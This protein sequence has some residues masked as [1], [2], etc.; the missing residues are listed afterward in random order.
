MLPLSKT[1]SQHAE[2]FIDDAHLEK[3]AGAADLVDVG[4]LREVIAK[5]LDK[6]ALTVEETAVLLHARDPEL[7]E[8]VFA[9]ARDLKQ[10]VYGNRI[11]LFAPLYL[12][13]LCVNDCAY[14]GFQNK[15]K[16]VVRRTL[17]MEEIRQ[18]VVAMEN[19]GH[20]RLI[21]VF[22]EHPRYDADFIAT[23]IRDIYDVRSGHGEIRRVNVNAAPLDHAGFKTMETYH[24]KT[25]A[26]VH[27]HGTPKGDYLWRLDALSRAFEVGQDDLGIGALFGLSNWRF[28]VLGLVSHAVFLKDRYGCGPH[29]ISFPRLRPASGVDLGAD[30]LVND[31][32]FKFLIAVLRLA[33]PYTGLILTA[34]ETAELRRSAMEFGVSQ[35]DAGSC[36]ELGGYTE[37]TCGQRMEREQFTL[38][39]M[40]PLDKVIRE[41]SEQGHVPSFCTACYRLGRTGEHF[42][43]FAI[44]GF[45]KR[46]CTPNALTTFMEYLVDYATPE[47]AK[48]GLAQIQVE[49]DKLEDSPMKQTLVERLAKVRETNERDMVF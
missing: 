44:P 3:L 14:C 25:Y 48:A 18:Q 7:R 30:N 39:D 31:E 22:G 41:L 37:Q 36:I 2:D 45:I 40:R 43:E 47:T 24:H 34:R 11:V 32:D 9:A 19:Q 20:K 4:R 29:T 42:M 26:R 1:L 12:G 5:A 23:C 49:L 13:N 6:Q 15:N 38:G 46:F 33:V 28:D 17:G 16:D 21:V 35:I 10:R 27:P 8:E